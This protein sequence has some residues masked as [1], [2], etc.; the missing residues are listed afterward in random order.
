MDSDP[1]SVVRELFNAFNDGDLDRAV[2]MVT[3]D[4]QSLDLAMGFSLRGR[5]GCRD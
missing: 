4:F 1:P 2:S 5:E 3:E